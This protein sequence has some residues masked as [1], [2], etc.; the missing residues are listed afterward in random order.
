MSVTLA[1][2]MFFSATGA[3]AA[4]QASAS[5]GNLAFTLIDLDP[6]DGIAP[7][8][9]ILANGGATSVSM[10]A[11]DNV[12]WEADGADQFRAGT[13]SFSQAF[14]SSLTNAGASASI[15]G[16]DLSVQGHAN[17]AGTSFEASAISGEVSIANSLTLSLSANTALL[18]TADLSLYASASNG[19]CLY[20]PQCNVYSNDKASA[21]GTL[22]LHYSYG[23]DNGLSVKED[24]SDALYLSAVS[25]PV[26]SETRGSFDPVTGQYQ[27]I[28]A[29]RH[30]ALDEAKGLTHAYSATFSNTS[31]R[32]QLASFGLLVSVSGQGS[33]APVPE[34]G[35]ACM[36]S[37]GLGLVALA[38]ALRRRRAA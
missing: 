1:C 13:F 31:S 18:I 3:M 7:S 35:T 14:A 8:L 10:R 20:A 37:M 23:L 27:E 26:W 15:Q 24:I 6:S 19:T 32:T 29:D 9:T 12:I 5:I 22:Y 33:T 16:L 38:L 28:D 34:A 4:S 30:E 36:A 2:G 11:E 17:G 25:T 21:R